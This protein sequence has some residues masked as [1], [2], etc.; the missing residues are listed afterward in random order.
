[1][2]TLL[3]CSLVSGTLVLSAS[4]IHAN[5]VELFS[6]FL[7]MKGIKSGALYNGGNVGLYVFN[8]QTNRAEKLK[9]Q[10][11]RE[12]GVAFDKDYGVRRTRSFKTSNLSFS[13]PARVRTL[14][15]SARVSPLLI[16][17]IQGTAPR[18]KRACIVRITFYERP[19]VSAEGKRCIALQGYIQGRTATGSW[20]FHFLEPSL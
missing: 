5:E 14:R 8:V 19:W 11:E 4:N 9:S 6:N 7:T 1:M 16:K 2:L 10:F 12:F 15:P 18:D 17:A 20:Q 13:P 3:A